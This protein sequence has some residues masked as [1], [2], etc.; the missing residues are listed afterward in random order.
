MAL[1]IVDRLEAIQIKHG[2]SEPELS[3]P[4][5]LYPHLEFGKEMPPVCQIGQAVLVG[6]A[7]VL[8]TQLLSLPAG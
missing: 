3:R 1:D 6:H 2:N 5:G 7:Q 8:V 4:T